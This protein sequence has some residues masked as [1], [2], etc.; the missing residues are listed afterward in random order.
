MGRND[1][2]TTDFPSEYTF[3]WDPM[4]ISFPR[5]ALPKGKDWARSPHKQA[6]GWHREGGLSKNVYFHNQKDFKIYCS[7]DLAVEN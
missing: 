5:C 3:S 4:V 2:S 7:M 1:P 6:Q